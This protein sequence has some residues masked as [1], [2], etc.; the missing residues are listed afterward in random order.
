MFRYFGFG[1]NMNMT[2]L[3]AKG[4]EPL[5][6]RRAVLHGWRLHFNVQHFFRH[7]GGVGNIERSDNPD[8]RVLGVLYDCPDEALEPLDA[9][10]AYGHGY[11]RITVELETEADAEPVNALTYVGMPEFIDDNCLPSRRY[12]NIV[13]DGARR[14]GLDTSYVQDLMAQ[15]VHQ[16]Q[17]YPPFSP[18]AGDYPLFNEGSLAQQPLYTA[19]WGAVFDMSA[20]RPL[21]EFLKG[22]FGGQ[23]MTLFHLKR[24][25]S[26][27]SNESMDDIRQG[28]LNEPQRHYLN[29][30]L[31][32][33]AREYR[34]V[35]RFSYEKN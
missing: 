20:A 28:R 17:D 13:V 30:Y 18:P 8:D 14:A 22:F 16:P 12:L 21:H 2:S 7:E 27:T 24:L 9:A 32:E 34:Y 33:Y 25:D 4:L 29:A 31:N 11:D 26:S 10:E 35:G 1:S 3:R 15:P 5:A 23:D 6:A 19:L